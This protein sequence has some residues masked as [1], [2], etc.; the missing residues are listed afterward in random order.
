MDRI[1]ERVN[2]LP[3]VVENLDAALESLSG[4]GDSFANIQTD[5]QGLKDL[6]ASLPVETAEVEAAAQLVADKAGALA[7]AARA[8]AASTPDPEAPPVA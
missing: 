7:D 3:T 8:I 6:I 4:M 2:L 5:I 1:E